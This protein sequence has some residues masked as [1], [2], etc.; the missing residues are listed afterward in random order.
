MLAGSLVGQEVVP[1]VAVTIMVYVDR[2]GLTVPPRFAGFSCGIPTLTDPNLLRNNAVLDCLIAQ[3]DPSVVR[4]GGCPCS[5]Q[6]R[7]A[8]T[9][10]WIRSTSNCPSTC[11]AAARRI[12]FYPYKAAALTRHAALLAAKEQTGQPDLPPWL[13]VKLL[14][15]QQNRRHADWVCSS[16][17]TTWNASFRVI[18]CCRTTRI[19]TPTHI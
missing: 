19:R 1:P 3:V 13:A 5:M 9:P 16:S 18:L 14:L 4:V 8:A 2:S 10:G 6:A 11:G 15:C 17:Y 12:L 7:K